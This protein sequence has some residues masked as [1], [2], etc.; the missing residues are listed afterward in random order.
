MNRVALLKCDGYHAKRVER[1]IREGFELLGGEEYIRSIIPKNSNILLKPNL[2]SVERVS[3]FLVAKEPILI[4]P[5]PSLQSL[6]RPSVLSTI[7]PAPKKRCLKPRPIAL[8]VFLIGFSLMDWVV[9]AS[10]VAEIV[11]CK[12]LLKIWIC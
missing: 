9:E 1:K 8:T 2:L 7:A 10:R 12:V 4:P 6:L 5:V 11:I 3:G